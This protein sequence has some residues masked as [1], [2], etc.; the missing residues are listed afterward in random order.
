ML[1]H[2]SLSVRYLATRKGC[3]TISLCYNIYSSL[4]SYP[5]IWINANVE[6][7]ILTRYWSSKVCPTS[8]T[9]YIEFDTAADILSFGL[10]F[11]VLICNCF[12]FRFSLNGSLLWYIWL[13]QMKH[14]FLVKATCR[15][16]VI[17]HHYLVCNLVWTFSYVSVSLLVASTFTWFS[18]R[19]ALS[20]RTSQCVYSI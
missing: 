12:E 6:L 15:V 17:N 9:K 3:G 13:K 16:L 11:A 20:F 5:Y 8:N 19:F 14:I 4:D 18:Y 10:M 1:T 2:H 7:L